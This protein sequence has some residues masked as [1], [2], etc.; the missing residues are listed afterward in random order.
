MSDTT[1][2][3]SLKDHIGETTILTESHPEVVAELTIQVQS[4]RV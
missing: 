2:I 4:I 1:P 3:R